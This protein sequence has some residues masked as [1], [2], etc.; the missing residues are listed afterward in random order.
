[1]ELTGFG[2]TDY[3]QVLDTALA[4]DW[5]ILTVKDYLQTSNPDEPFVV[6]RH[7][8]DRRVESTVT[9]ADIEADRD[10][11]STYYFRMSTFDSNI[12]QSLSE[13]GHEIGYHYEDLAKTGGDQQTARE[14]FA[15]NLQ[16]FR[17]Y[18]DVST[19]CA[20]GSPL[21]PYDNTDLWADI[22][23]LDAYDLLGEAYLSIDAATHRPSGP[24]YLS[25]TGRNWD[26]EL[27]EF[28]R[29]QTTADVIELLRSQSCSQLYLLVH[30][31]RWANSHFEFLQRASW[32]LA[33][34]T[35]KSAVTQLHH[36]HSKRA[37]DA[38]PEPSSDFR[39]VLQS[40]FTR[41]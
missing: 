6:L 31:C 19:V 15:K 32:D 30:P 27:P 8:V 21:S 18:V 7:D 20:H 16:T 22:T 25:D 38:P 33:A 17:R 35:A 5:N 39:I 40:L 23:N 4:N 28:G 11:Q 9:M 24:V 13:Q 41:R 36:R 12:V 37:T 34:E 10:I 26:V 2:F 14:R 1:M 3:E 29:V